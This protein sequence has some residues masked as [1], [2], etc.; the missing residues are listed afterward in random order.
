MWC[1]HDSIPELADACPQPAGEWLIGAIVSDLPAVGAALAPVAP[2][3]EAAATEVV[4]VV[5]MAMVNR[6]RH[7]V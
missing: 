5:A 1:P 7:R 2:A 4:A 6:H 3:A